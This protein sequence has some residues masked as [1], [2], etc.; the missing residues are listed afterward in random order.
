MEPQACLAAVRCREDECPSIRRELERQRIGQGGGNEVGADLGGFERRAEV[1]HGERGRQHD[2]KSAH[3]PRCLLDDAVDVRQPRRPPPDRH[4]QARQA[5]RR[6]RS[7]CPRPPASDGLPVLLQTA[8]EQPPDPGWG[9]GRQQRPVGIGLQHPPRLHP[10][11]SRPAKQPDVRST[12]RTARA[13]RPD[14]RPPIDVAAPAPAPGDMYAAVPRIVPHCVI[15]GDCVMLPANYRS[16]AGDLDV[17][18][19]WPDRSRVL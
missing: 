15:A 4:H 9:L 3:D 6:F 13:E 2:G 1:R 10:R 16:A 5:L 18:T 14:V 17:R 11:P 19:P 7:G 8:P 12:S